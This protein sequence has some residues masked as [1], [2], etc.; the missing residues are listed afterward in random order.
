MNKTD[1]TRGYYQVHFPDGSFSIASF[2][3]EGIKW[4][5]NWV[6]KNKPSYKKSMLNARGTF[7]EFLKNPGEGKGIFLGVNHQNEALSLPQ[8]WEPWGL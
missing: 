6:L 8:D 2:T 1:L 7:I 4:F 3:Q 5:R